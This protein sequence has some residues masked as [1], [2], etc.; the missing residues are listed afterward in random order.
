MKKNKSGLKILLTLIVFIMLSTL[1]VTSISA[2]N[3]TENKFLHATTKTNPKYLEWQELSDNEKKNTIMPMPYEIKLKDSIKRSTYN[4]MTSSAFNSDNIGADYDLR[5]ILAEIIVK[6]QK[7]TGDCWA[8]SSTSMIETTLAKKYGTAEEMSP[9]HLEYYV[10]QNFNKPVGDGANTALTFAYL[11]SGKGPAHENDFPFSSVYSETDNLKANYYLKE[12]SEVTLTQEVRAQMTESTIFANIYKTYDQTTGKPICTDAYE[13]E[14]TEAQVQ[15]LRNLVKEHISTYGGVTAVYHA[16]DGNTYEQYVEE[17]TKFYNEAT[18]AYYCNDSELNSNHQITIVGW[19]DNYSKTNFVTQ[20]ANDGAWIILNSWGVE[21]GEEGYL[22]ISYDDCHIENMI[23]GIDEIYTISDETP[24]KY[25]NLYEYDFLGVNDAYTWGE[26]EMYGAN[27]FTREDPTQNEYLNSVGISLLDA[28]GVEV[29][30]NSES[31]DLTSLTKV[32]SYTGSE[33]L[34]AGYHTIDI[35]PTELTGDKFA[36][37]IKY[38]NADDAW[39]PFELNSKDTYGSSYSSF[40]DKATSNAN[41][42]FLSFDGTDWYDCYNLQVSQYPV[43]YLTNTNVCI[44]AFT[45]EQEPVVDTTV[46]VTG[47]TLDKETAEVNTGATVALT[48][49]VAPSNATNQNVTWSTS[50]EAVATVVDGVVTGV[51]EG[52]AT[53][54]VT[55]VDGN[56]TDTCEITVTVPEVTTVPVTGV[57][58]NK[59]SGTIKEGETIQLVATIMPTNA[60]NQNVTWSTSDD[61]VATVSGGVVTG[62][63]E[64]TATITVTTVEGGKTATATITVEAEEEVTI[65]PVT[66]VSLNTN[67]VSLEVGGQYTLVAE[68]NPTDATNKNVNWS[69]SNSSVVEVTNKGIITAKSEGTATITV[70]TEDGNKTATATVTVTKKTNTD[71]DIYTD[72]DAG[73]DE[74]PD[75]LPGDLPQTGE[76]LLIVGLIVMVLAM[77]IVSVIKFKKYNLR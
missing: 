65:V 76:K 13:I 68:I 63:A 19:D 49:T 53:I 54:T 15:A 45:T 30:I 69:S 46:A 77:G 17:Y 50:D 44:K 41:E 73:K 75:T 52:T 35:T 4:L 6:D 31:D 11:A 38:I 57:T 47:V 24:L 20:P 33:A 2:A 66:S 62:V 56:Y 67:N 43:Q 18:S 27:V 32:A 71:D 58:L 3:T 34:T 59:N 74:E 8:F 5:E 29:Y 48:A 36:I 28:H 23:M 55:T 40:W 14:Y 70:T 9:M 10:N 12:S 64:G 16:P 21:F 22:Y 25:D 26:P 61:T 60:T 1:I 37:A 72:P 39:V 42:S 7:Q 51:A